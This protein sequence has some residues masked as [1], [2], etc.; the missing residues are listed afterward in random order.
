MLDHQLEEDRVQGKK[1]E[2]TQTIITFKCVTPASPTHFDPTQT[3]AYPT[4][5][6]RS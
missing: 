3:D 2:D 5:V 6:L 4:T 1:V